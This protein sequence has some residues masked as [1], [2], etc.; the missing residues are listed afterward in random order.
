M[1][2]RCGYLL[3]ECGRQDAVLTKRLDV[4]GFIIFDHYDRYG[5]FV[6][7]V[8]GYLRAGRITYR[9]TVAEGIENA[10]AAFMKLL[11]GGNFGK[12]LVAISPDPTL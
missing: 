5:A 9:E 2:G 4:K 1:P 6:K 3:R 10:P 8:G 12:Q 11:K 7:E